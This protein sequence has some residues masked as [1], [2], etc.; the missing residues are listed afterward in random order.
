[1]NM[2]GLPPGMIMTSSAIRSRRS[3]YGDR[4]PRPRAT[5][6]CRSPGCSHG[7][8]RATPSRS[9]D[10]VVGRAKIRLS[11]TEIDDVASFRGKT[12]GAGEHRES[13]LLADP[14][15]SRDGTKHESPRTFACGLAAAAA[16]E[17]CRGLPRRWAA[18]QP[19]IR[20][21]ANRPSAK[22]PRETRPT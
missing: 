8:H 5:A 11:D 18:V 22:G 2:V 7:G 17:V 4:R 20:W 10:D 16:E 15:E 14:I 21:I 19:I 13:V 12:R 1:M 3:A 6:G 9:L